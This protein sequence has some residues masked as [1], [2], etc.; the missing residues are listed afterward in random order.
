MEA[1]TKN[2]ELM[3]CPLFRLLV[4]NSTA[5]PSSD[6]A[7]TRWKNPGDNLAQGAFASAVFPCKCL[8]LAGNEF[9]VHILQCLYTSKN[10][11]YAFNLD[12]IRTVFALHL[13]DAA[14]PIKV[15]KN[16]TEKAKGSNGPHS[17]SNRAEV[18]LKTCYCSA[19]FT[20]GRHLLSPESES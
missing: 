12:H 7:G 20:I 4:T 2:N 11:A 3:D 5:L 1:F 10:F 13:V 17:F 8:H 14:L 19:I 9:C 16:V 6:P 15:Y 18:T